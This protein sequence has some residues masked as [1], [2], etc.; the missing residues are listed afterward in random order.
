MYKEYIS[1]FGESLILTPS[2]LNDIRHELI[3]DCHAEYG[4]LLV[5]CYVHKDKDNDNQY[6]VITDIRYPA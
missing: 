1:G 6:A 4:G 2:E 5:Q 3:F